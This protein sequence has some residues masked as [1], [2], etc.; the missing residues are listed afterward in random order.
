MRVIYQ[1]I[2]FTTSLAVIGSV[3]WLEL[4]FPFFLLVLRLVLVEWTRLF[5]IKYSHK[6]FLLFFDTHK[7]CAARITVSDDQL[8]SIDLYLWLIFSKYT[9]QMRIRRN[10]KGSHLMSDYISLLT[11]WI[12]ISPVR[13]PL[14][15]DISLCRFFRFSSW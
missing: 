6:I 15:F 4:M 12:Q 2:V 9:D 13:K 8:C 14:C 7:Y 1:P 5:R 11:H 3:F 10:W